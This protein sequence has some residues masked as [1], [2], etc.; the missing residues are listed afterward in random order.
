MF[1]HIEMD[2][3][4]GRVVIKLLRVLEP[5]RQS[6]EGAVLYQQIEQMLT[7]IVDEHSR[8]EQAYSSIT[9]VLLAAYIQHLAEDSPLKFQIRILQTR[10]QA[11][12]SAG[13]L[14]LLDDFIKEYSIEVRHMEAFDSQ[15]LE[16]ALQ[17]LI[18][19]FGLSPSSVSTSAVSPVIPEE[20]PPVTQQP[21]QNDEPA[22]QVAESQPLINSAAENQLTAESYMQSSANQVSS[23][24]RHHLD[25]RRKD[26]QKLQKDLSE[27]VLSAISQHEEFAIL[28]DVVMESLNQV[29]N[30]HEVESLRWSMQQEIGKLVSGS[31]TLVESLNDTHQ[32]L[33]LV[34]GDSRQL[35]DELERVHLLSMTDELTGKPNRRAFLRQLEDEMARAERYGAP[36]S[37]AMI[38]IDFFKQI[39]DKY[40]HAAGDDV[41][42]IYSNEVLSIF[43]HHDMVS[44]YGGEEFAILLPNTDIDGALRALN[45]VKKRAATTR[46][47]NEG[48]MLAIPTFSAGCA[49][50]HKG[51]KL[52]NLIERVDQSLYRA[53]HLGRNRIEIDS[54]SNLDKNSVNSQ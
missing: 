51:E 21:T 30:I 29:E 18:Q 23:A 1:N 48:D 16:Q 4:Q 36:L 8:Y 49:L 33:E 14:K 12:L 15:L 52:I 2:F 27:H 41:L 42:Q 17:P 44:R 37:V 46:W 20:E 19:A 40:G 50:Y 34:E 31:H 25:E 54:T 9:Q 10:L 13:D 43:R 3:S 7:E 53:K 11:P 24:Y 26:I 28:L 45:K 38:D 47:N 5:L 32:F 35:S 6:H 22:Y 39:N